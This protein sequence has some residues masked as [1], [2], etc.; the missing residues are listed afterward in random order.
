MAYWLTPA[1]PTRSFFASTIAELAARFDAPPFEPHVTIYAT[2]E[3]EDIP[4][5][6]LSRALIDCNPLRLSVR[7][8]GHS[9][10]FT[11]AVFVEF[12]PSPPLSELRRAL[13]QASVLRD[14]YQLNPHLS[15][16]YKE[17]T[18]SAKTEVAAAVNLPFAEVLFDSAKA[19]ICPAR[20]KSR[21][22]V[23]AWRIAAVQRLTA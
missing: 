14:A 13:R 20:I 1:E 22:D 19:V 21:Q 7:K 23:E 8:I 11:K 9:D 6:V 18:R 12:E 17:M 4:G 16:I 15:L 5:E 10:E 3:G 2:R